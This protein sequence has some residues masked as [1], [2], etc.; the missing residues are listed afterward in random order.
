MILAEN[1]FSNKVLFMM[2]NISRIVQPT[3]IIL[4]MRMITGENRVNIGVHNFIAHDYIFLVNKFSL[5]LSIDHSQP[6]LLQTISN[7][8][9]NFKQSTLFLMPR[10]L[11]CFL[12]LL[13]LQF[14]RQFREMFFFCSSFNIHIVE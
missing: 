5:S 4:V 2:R 1:V 3:L 13:F 12:L 14:L 7:I 8:S 10:F 6:K 9:N 11:C